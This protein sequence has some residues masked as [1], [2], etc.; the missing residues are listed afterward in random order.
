M[1]SSNDTPPILGKYTNREAANYS[2]VAQGVH[3]QVWCPKPNFEHIGITS[4][5]QKLVEIAGN[6]DLQ[7]KIQQHATECGL[8]HVRF[9]VML[10]DKESQGCNLCVYYGKKGQPLHISHAFKDN[11]QKLFSI[12][13]DYRDGNGLE[14]SI[15]NLSVDAPSF[16]GYIK[17]LRSHHTKL[18]DIGAPVHSRN[19]RSR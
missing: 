2:L 11:L 10:R 6:A 19:D 12:G 17:K 1:I 8:D 16:E 18:L 13:K 14:W 3:L 9:E 5:K 7:A 15:S 4:I